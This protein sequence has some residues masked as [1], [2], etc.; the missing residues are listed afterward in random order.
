MIIKKLGVLLLAV[1]IGLTLSVTPAIY[2]TQNNTCPP[3]KTCHSTDKYQKTKLKLYFFI[4]AKDI[5]IRDVDALTI[6][7]NKWMGCKIKLFSINKKGKMK[8][9]KTGFKN[10]PIYIYIYHN[11][12]MILN[13]KTKAGTF[14]FFLPHLSAG[15][16]TMEFIYHGSQKHHL[17]PC[18]TTIPLHV[19]D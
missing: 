19:I 13:K 8:N 17:L 4:F 9:I 10:Y 12:E 7:N 3:G 11:G 16:Y 6:K 15:N 2:A 1:I 14:D 5:N 18:N